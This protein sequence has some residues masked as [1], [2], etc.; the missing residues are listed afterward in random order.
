MFS[1][2]LRN[3]SQIK[4]QE[5]FL[6][7]SFQH[8]FVLLSLSAPSSLLTDSGLHFHHMEIIK[9]SS[10]CPFLVGVDGGDKGRWMSLVSTSQV[11]AFMTKHSLQAVSHYKS[12]EQD[13]LQD[14][15]VHTVFFGL[16]NLRD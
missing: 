1:R 7:I 12:G 16:C 9:R 13:S 6:M 4:A 11:F 14:S 15:S 8:A 5:Y 2:D 3:S 10:K